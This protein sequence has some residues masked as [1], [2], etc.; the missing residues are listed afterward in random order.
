LAGLL[1]LSRLQPKLEQA[2]AA[3]TPFKSNLEQQFE[4]HSRQLERERAEVTELRERLKAMAERHCRVDG[5]M[6]SLVLDA[7]GTLD[8]GPKEAAFGITDRSALDS[9]Y[10]ALE[11]HD[12]SSSEESSEQREAAL[13]L[14]VVRVAVV[15]EFAALDAAGRQ[16]APLLARL[17][18]V[19]V[20]LYDS[21]ELAQ[22]SGSQSG[23]GADVDDE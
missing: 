14:Q 1:T 10:G 18:D 12:A 20:A 23:S 3:N 8:G 22:S 16:V 21:L 13:E 9:P 15:R 4:Y 6:S 2:L 5:M 17:S 7:E 19:T 11:C